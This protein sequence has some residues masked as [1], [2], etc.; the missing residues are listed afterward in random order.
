MIFVVLMATVM[1]I[2]MVACNDSKDTKTETS[3]Q[4]TTK[5]PES[6]AAPTTQ[7]ASSAEATT[8]EP[9]KTIKPVILVVSFG[10]SYNDNRDLTI[11]AIE[12]EIASAFPD[13]EVRRAF[14][15]QIIID[16]LK[17]RDSLVIDNVIE[18]MDRLVADG[19]KEVVVQPT[20]VMN[21][22]EFDD[23]VKEVK[24]YKDKFESLKFGKQLLANQSD[25]E[26]VMNALIKETA[27]FDDGNTAF[28][29]VGHGTEHKANVTYEKLQKVFN[30]NDKKHYL[31]GTV[32]AEP[33]YD[34]VLA[35][36]KESE[37]QRVFLAPLMVVAGDHANNDI[38]GDEDD[39]WKVMLTKEG[40]E[41]IPHVQGLGQYADVRKIYV[42]HVKKAMDSPSV[43]G[44]VTGALLNPGEYRGIEVDSSSSMFKIV[45]CVLTVAEDGSMSAVLTLSG[46]GYAKLFM[47]T[48]EK[49]LKAEE[50][51]FIPFV[52]NADG[53]YTYTVPVEA[54]DQPIDC[55]AFSIRK[56]S[57]Y[58]RTIQFSSDSLPVEAFK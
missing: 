24:Q 56:E 30:E 17:K 18:A 45:D 41:V 2:S 20:H 3:V 40:F 52:E 37:K 27:S 29:F 8:T 9:E 6:S 11:G 39:A 1:V 43:I 10:T 49:A 48:G 12:N 26:D 16:I 28:V 50:T 22:F 31:I 14:T 47:G 51:Q 46:K 54:L 36:L 35:A 25:Y 15:S 4:N 7:P 53:K 33:T 58:D 38:C 5:Q 21:G 55:A 32:E 34:T 23:V 42:D 57:W 19:V 44:P 13:Y